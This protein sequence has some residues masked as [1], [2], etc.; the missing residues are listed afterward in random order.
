MLN[1]VFPC[2]AATTQPWLGLVETSV[3]NSSY[4]ATAA[5]LMP[6]TLEATAF[7]GN[8]NVV[9]NLT[10]SPSPNGTV[11]L[12]AAGSINGLQPNDFGLIS[13]TAG[14]GFLWGTSTINLSDANPNS[15]PGLLHPIVFDGLAVAATNVTSLQR[16]PTQEGYWAVTPKIPTTVPN[17]PTSLLPSFATFFAESGSFTGSHGVLQTQQALH[18]T[19]VIAGTNSL[20]PLHANDTTGPIQ[21]DAGTGDISGLTLFAGKA[22]QVIAGNNITDVALYIQNDKAS[23]IS[24]VDAGRDI[25][26]YDP[27]SSLRLAGTTMGNALLNAT[28]EAGDIQISGP[29]TLEVLAGRNL[30]LGVGPSNDDGTAV[31]ITSIGNARNPVLPFAGANITAGAGLDGSQLVFTDNHG[32]GFIDQ[33][34]NPA[35]GGAE[36]A[37]Y[38]PVLGTMLGLNGADDPWA[39]FNQLPVENQ[40][41]LALDLF[42]LVLRDAGHTFSDPSSPTYK[43]K[44]SYNP[45]FS[46]I[47]DLF[48]GNAWQGDISLTSRDIKTENGGNIDIFAPGGQLTVGLPV[49]GLAADQGILTQHGGNISIFTKG[50]V[51]VGV[52]RIFTF[53]G[54]N[55]IIWSST[56]NIAAGSASKTVQSAPPTRVLVDPQSGNIEPDLAGLATGG[57]IGVLATVPGVPIGNVSLIAPA[58]TV[59]AGDAGIRA[60]GK[61]DIAATQVL[62]ATA[63]SSG[64][65]HESLAP[66]RHRRRLVS[67]SITAASNTSS[68]SAN[69]AAEVAKQGH[70]PVQQE[71]FPSIITVEVLGYGGG[72]S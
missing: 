70:S 2:S 67:S 14:N 7:S 5:A 31:G 19:S 62:N 69:A 51:N 39:V 37:R 38:L 48:P 64:G 53:L 24:V 22:A 17:G 25:I 68:A 16:A 58:G 29:G 44:I 43:N 27:N 46:A 55:E 72:D 26:A 35:T 66:R 10:L 13:P 32:T 54:G 59:D 15:L 47:A 61:V 57:G 18:G 23:D 4:F 71:E 33:F 63:I 28:P 8:L 30:N 52:S 56:G 49:G 20:G 9:G 11:D 45:G 12:A 50:N 42:Y 6:G 36:A 41:G 21:L 3:T 60:T 34:L 65:R 40:D 1:Q